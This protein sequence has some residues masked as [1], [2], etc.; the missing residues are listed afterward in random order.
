MRRVS[1]H[2]DELLRQRRLVVC[3]GPGGVGKTTCAASLALRA[4]A[5]GRRP[6][7]LTIDPARR[8]ADALGLGTAAPGGVESEAGESESGVESQGGAEFGQSTVLGDEARQVPGTNVFA[9]MLDTK[10]SY[11]ALIAR[12]A[13]PEEQAQIFGNR[14]YQAFSRTLARS[15]AYVAA[16]RLYF[17]LQDER[18]DLVILDTPPTRSALEIL[19]APGSLARFLDDGVLRQWLETS[20]PGAFSWKRFAQAGT[21]AASKALGALVGE[22]LVSEM[23]TF[24]R[25]LLAQRDGFLERA[26]AVQQWLR[27]D[28]TAYVLVAAA[29]G[30]SLFDA[31]H[32]GASLRQKHRPAEVLLFNRA[33]QLRC[34][35]VTP[36]PVRTALEGRLRAL[37]DQ[38][39]E[40]QER[41][42]ALARELRAEVAPDATLLALGR[43][44]DFKVDLSWVRAVLEE[45]VVLKG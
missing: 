27:S 4:D 3:V 32:L 23:L 13:T 39:A 12:I 38:A 2:V 7:L 28:E 36:P 37:W 26:Q 11:D 22:G 21:V 30:T 1:E 25:V 33:V 29:A 5:L 14:V 31:R 18:F 6:F 40:E 10:A 17:A 42:F 15:H 19:D 41:A 45:P 44:E 20:E 8:L 9:A 34:R 43:M 35:A 24:F 16:E